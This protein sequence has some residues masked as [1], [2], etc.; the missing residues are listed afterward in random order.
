VVEFKSRDAFTAGKHRGLGQV[1][2]L[3]S[4]DEALQDIL[5]N[6]KIVVA[7]G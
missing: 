1:M 6:V 4:I 3:A 5:L 7:D 2:E